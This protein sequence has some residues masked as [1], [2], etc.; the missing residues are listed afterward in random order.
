MVTNPGN[1]LGWLC[2]CHVSSCFSSCV[3]KN[4]IYLKQ[5]KWNLLTSNKIIGVFVC[6]FTLTCAKLGWENYVILGSSEQASVPR[7]WAV[8][9]FDIWGCLHC[10]ERVP[11]TSWRFWSLLFKCELIPAVSGFLQ[12][13]FQAN[14]WEQDL[15]SSSQKA[16]GTR[17]YQSGYHHPIRLSNMS[18]QILH[19]QRVWCHAFRTPDICP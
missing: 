10:Q 3:L 17:L 7:V 1:S 16:V 19:L 14:L 2:L 5:W 9:L 15:K 13:K 12:D 11:G 8:G 18:H 6:F 4:L